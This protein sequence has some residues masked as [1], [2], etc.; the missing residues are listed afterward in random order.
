MHYTSL[1]K[2]SSILLIFDVLEEIFPFLN[3]YF[4]EYHQGTGLLLLL[5]R[6][7]QTEMG[8]CDRASTFRSM[9]NYISI[10]YVNLIIE[11]C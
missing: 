10:V 8:V 9:E 2:I 6:D 7:L 3:Y 11:V 4:W 5:P 1:V